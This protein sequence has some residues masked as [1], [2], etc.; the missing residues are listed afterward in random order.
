MRLAESLELYWDRDDKICVDLSAQ[1]P[2]LRIPGELEK[3]H[4]DR[5]LPMAPEFSQFLLATPEPDRT[6]PVFNPKPKRVKGPRLLS[7]R[8]GELVSGIGK[9]AGVKVAADAKT[10]NVKYASAHDLRR[11]FGE[12]WAAR[13]MP[14]DLMILMRHENIDM[15]MRFYVGRNAQNTAK[16]L[17]EA[18]KRATFG[19]TFGDRAAEPSSANEISPIETGCLGRAYEVAEEGLEPP[20]RGL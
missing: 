8:V 9:A 6:G 7:H 20:T 12:R 2:M 18:H 16:T 17:W 5:L 13:I 11:S 19:N 15:T 3:G 14:P 10:G 4:R 1:H